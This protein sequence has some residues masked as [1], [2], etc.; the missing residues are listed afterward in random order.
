MGGSKPPLG[1][2]I[3]ACIPILAS[4]SST[5]EGS[6]VPRRYST[7]AV[8]TTRSSDVPDASPTGHP[9]LLSERGMS[10]RTLLNVHPSARFEVIVFLALRAFA[11][12]YSS[13]LLGRCL[14]L[15]DSTCRVRRADAYVVC[16]S[17]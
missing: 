10:R 1:L 9:A 15:L 4:A 16:T 8:E 5:G 3:A 17:G 14:E 7:S 2:V 11:V 13:A 12:V 6:S